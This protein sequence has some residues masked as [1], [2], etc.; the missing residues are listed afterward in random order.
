MLPRSEEFLYRSI[1]HSKFLYY[2]KLCLRLIFVQ[3]FSCCTIMFPIIFP[4]LQQL[5]T[6][7]MW[8][9]HSRSATIPLSWTRCQH[10]SNF[11]LLFLRILTLRTVSC[12]R[13]SPGTLVTNHVERESGPSEP[14]QL[15]FLQTLGFVSE[16]ILEPANPASSCIPSSYFVATKR[17][18]EELLTWSLAKFLDYILVK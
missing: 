16:A 4:H 7:Y 18:A 14:S 2:V 17:G 8:K 13:S 6:W 15:T 12:H 3:L 9:R 1:I 11:L 5:I 10:I